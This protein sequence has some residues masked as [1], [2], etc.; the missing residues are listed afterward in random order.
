MSTNIQKGCGTRV[1]K[2]GRARIL[3][4]EQFLLNSLDLADLSAKF[5]VSQAEFLNT[6]WN[7]KQ[8]IITSKASPLTRMR[9]TRVPLVMPR[10]SKRLSLPT[11]YAK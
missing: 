1:N 3:Q 2:L 7:I 9:L 6:V 10:T 4:S 8:K 11:K 5:G